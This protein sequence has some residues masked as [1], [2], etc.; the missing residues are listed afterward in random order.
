MAAILQWSVSE[1]I[2]NRITQLLKAVYR[3]R[4][5]FYI[6]QSCLR[7]LNEAK[8]RNGRQWGEIKNKFLACPYNVKP[9]KTIIFQR[10]KS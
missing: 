4:S 3:F 9:S 6:P 1:K 5:S 8:K 7:K 10:T 2:E